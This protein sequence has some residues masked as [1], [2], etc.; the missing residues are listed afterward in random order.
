MLNK[1]SEREKELL[2]STYIYR[3]EFDTSKEKH[4]RRIT[5]IY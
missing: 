4:V 2:D 5:D 3:K 1:A